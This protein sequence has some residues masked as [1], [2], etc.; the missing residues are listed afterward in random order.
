MTPASKTYV[1]EFGGAMAAYVILM[2]SIVWLVQRLGDSPWRF[3]LV[4]AVPMALGVA[5]FIR[6]LTRMDELHQ[7][8]QLTGLAFATGS[9]ALLTFTYGMLENVGLPHLSWLWVCPLTVMLWG[10]G[11]AWTSRRYQ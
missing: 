8:I 11:T 9:I 2:F 10:L 7:R 5:A 6:F 4:P 3:A 1:R